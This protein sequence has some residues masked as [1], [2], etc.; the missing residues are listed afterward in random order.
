MKPY[1]SLF[2]IRALCTFSFFCF[3]LTL[4][5][6]QDQNLSFVFLDPL[7]FS[8][9]LKFFENEVLIDV[10]TYEEFRV[11]RIKNAILA[12][13]REELSNITDTLD[14]E[15]PLFVYCEE[16]S[17]STTVGSI[18]FEQGFKQV[19]LLKGGV[20]GWRHEGFAVDTSRISKW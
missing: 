7:E 8:I 3:W 14:L 13:D 9:Q 4:Y 2:S 16:E 20:S 15:Q 12:R 5:S 6:Q 11:E 18:L 19:V 17:R 1:Y 10:R